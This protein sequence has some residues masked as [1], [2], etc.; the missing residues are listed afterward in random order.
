MANQ[1]HFKWSK[2]LVLISGTI[3]KMQSELQC[4]IHVATHE[5]V[6]VTAEECD[7][8]RLVGSSQDFMRRVRKGQCQEV[9]NLSRS[10]ANLLIQSS[11]RWIGILISCLYC[12]R[13]LC[14]RTI[15][16]VFQS[17]YP[18]PKIFGNRGKSRFFASNRISGWVVWSK[19]MSTRIW[20]RSSCQ[21]MENHTLEW[22]S[23][24]RML[25]IQ[26]SLEN[27]LH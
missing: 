25:T 9:T 13:L 5:P 22:W 7:S 20:K 14:W 23:L 1:I 2:Y 19:V 26:Y 24:Y 12:T 16:Q 27:L 17:G 8:V 10:G 3:G 11:S 6:I 21:F 15:N 4:I 18:E